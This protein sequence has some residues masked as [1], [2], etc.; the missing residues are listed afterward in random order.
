M[1][2][3]AMPNL[4]KVNIKVN[5]A[6]NILF[7]PATL[8][9]NAG[10]QISWTNFDLTDHLPGVINSDGTCVGL[11]DRP[12]PGNGGVS[13]TFSPSPQYDSNNNQVAYQFAYT[14][15]DNRGITGAMNVQPTP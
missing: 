4:Y 9:V 11:V 2:G 15:C 8:N 3:S 5:G 10:D 1:G 6:G 13:V 7:D 14:C 12:V